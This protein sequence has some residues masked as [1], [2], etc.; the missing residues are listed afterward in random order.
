MAYEYRE[1]P[2]CEE[3]QGE[4]PGVKEH[5]EA[6]AEASGEEEEGKGRTHGRVQ[7]R[8]QLHPLIPAREDIAS[9][10]DQEPCDDARQHRLEPW[11]FGAEMGE[12]PADQALGVKGVC[13]DPKQRQLPET[14][15]AARQLQRQQTQSC[16]ADSVQTRRPKLCRHPGHKRHQDAAHGTGRAVGGGLGPRLEQHVRQLGGGRE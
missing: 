15:Q 1:Q 12:G 3:G 7:E 13:C 5:G 2:G 14:W 10:A 4:R 9:V 11:A 16:Q 6:H 8:A